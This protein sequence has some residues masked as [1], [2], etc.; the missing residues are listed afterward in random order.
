M[1]Y[2]GMHEL[3]EHAHTP[4]VTNEVS[5]LALAK[6]SYQNPEHYLQ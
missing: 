1:A 2:P 3:T 4:P 5:L 6:Q